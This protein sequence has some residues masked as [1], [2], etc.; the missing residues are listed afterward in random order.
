MGDFT[1]RLGTKKIILHELVLS[2]VRG[3]ERENGVI[4]SF[5]QQCF[6]GWEL[7]LKCRIDEVRP[8]V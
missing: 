2:V 3:L 7:R 6:F 1:Q 4:K 8:K 5:S